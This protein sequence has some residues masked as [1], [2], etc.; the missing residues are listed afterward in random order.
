MPVVAGLDDRIS[1]DSFGLGSSHECFAYGSQC[2][3]VAQIV[4]LDLLESSCEFV[5]VVE[6]LLCG[7]GHWN[8]LRYFGRAVM[9]WIMSSSWTPCLRALVAISG[10][11]TTPS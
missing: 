7:S 3:C 8:H 10:V 2:G 4:G 9:A 1:E 11:S 5:S 6:N